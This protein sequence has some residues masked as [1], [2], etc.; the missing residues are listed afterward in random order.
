MK[1]DKIE[2]K[3]VNDVL[4]NYDKYVDDL[5]RLRAIIEKRNNII[6]KESIIQINN[7]IL[8]YNDIIELGFNSKSEVKELVF[9]GNSQLLIDKIYNDYNEFETWL[10]VIEKSNTEI[11]NFLPLTGEKILSFQ[12]SKKAIYKPILSYIKLR[13]S[14][15]TFFEPI[16]EMLPEKIDKYPLTNF[17]PKQTEII[18]ALHE[19]G[20]FEYLKDKHSVLKM[21]ANRMANIINLIT[22]KPTT[23]LVSNINAMFSP[24]QK[25]TKNNPLNSPKIVNKVKEKLS[26]QLSN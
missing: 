11:S 2:M 23:S 26:K 9:K 17:D 18:I 5:K 1:K 6:D 16:L 21:S 8:S 3:Y 25:E 13:N 4:E 15:Y 12:N 19:L 22:G 24:K 7:S 14:L 10:S 20:I